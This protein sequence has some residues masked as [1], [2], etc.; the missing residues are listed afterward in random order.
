[1]SLAWIYMLAGIAFCLAG[2]FLFQRSAFE[3]NRKVTMP[4]LV[5]VL[6]I[7]LVS[8]GMAKKTGLIN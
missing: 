4:L 2:I 5:I 7:I 3:E 8:I 6:G 1:M